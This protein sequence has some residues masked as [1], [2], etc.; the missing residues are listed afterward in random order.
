MLASSDTELR[1]VA[2]IEPSVDEAGFALVRVKI[3]G[4][5]SRTT[6]Q[7]MAERR[8]GE[9]INVDDCADLSRMISAIFEVEDPI[10]GAYNLEVSSPGLDRPLTRMPDFERFRGYEAKLETTAPHLGR[11]RFRGRLD[12]LSDSDVVIRLEDD[13]TIQIPFVALAQAKLVLT[14]DLMEAALKGRLG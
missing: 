9:V 10:A 1:V 3:V 5:Q 12:G 7:I 11:K 2:L 8:D 4:G 6:L 14:D 13:S